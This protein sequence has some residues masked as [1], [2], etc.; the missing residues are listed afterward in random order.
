MGDAHERARRSRAARRRRPL[1][2]EPGAAPPRD[3]RGVANSILVKVNQIGTLT[4]TLEAIALAQAQRLHG[5]H[6]APLG[7]DRGHDDRRPRGRARHRADQDGR[8][9]AHPT[10][11]RSTTSSSGSR[12]S[13]AS[14]AEYP[15]LGRLP[16]R[17]PLACLAHG[18]RR[19]AARRSS[20]RSGPRRPTPEVLAR[21][22]AGDGRRAAQLLARH[23]RGSRRARAA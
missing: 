8:A 6:V 23:A 14:R 20:P 16:P 17:A 10:A 21:S 4:E 22:D 9:R 2:D 19:R 3:R 7:R 11:S 12:R 15:G 5:G 13:S 18:R 1:R